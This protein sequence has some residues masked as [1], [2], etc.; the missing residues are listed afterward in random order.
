MKT[1]H[2]T[3][4]TFVLFC[5]SGCDK[6]LVPV[7]PVPI[8]PNAPTGFGGIIRFNNWPR[9]DSVDQVV[10]ELRVVAFKT[11]PRDTTGLIFEFLRG[12]VIVY[13]A[14]GSTAFS[15]RDT[16]GR[17]R[18]TLHYA[19]VFEPGADSL[20]A[21]YQYVAMAWRYGANFFADWRPAG[22]Y[23]TQ[24]GTFNPGSITVRKNIY[25]GNI[26]INCDFRNPPP[27]PWG[28]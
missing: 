5:F 6:G 9:S 17:L 8:D 18:D 15:K 25:L 20:L 3:V 27:R 12:N 19:I 16:S 24:P 4:L 28:Q 2:I 22:V 11:P 10:Q 21:T 7:P 13:P 14:V 23:T 1:R 26:D